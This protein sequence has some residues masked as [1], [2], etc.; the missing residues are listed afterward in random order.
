MSHSSEEQSP[1]SPLH[2]AESDHYSSAAIAKSFPWNRF[3]DALALQETTK[4][5]LVSEFSQNLNHAHRHPDRGFDLSP[6]PSKILE[7]H[8]IVDGKKGTPLEGGEYHFSLT[9]PSDYPFRRPR[10]ELHTENAKLHY[11]RPITDFIGGIETDYAVSWSLVDFIQGMR[12]LLH[13]PHDPSNDLSIDSTDEEVRD[14]ARHSQAHLVQN[15]AER[16]FLHRVFP[17]R[18]TNWYK[19]VWRDVTAKDHSLAAKLEHPDVVLER[20]GGERAWLDDATAHV[21]AAA[22]QAAATARSRRRASK[23]KK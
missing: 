6:H 3:D 18:Y 22:G 2:A 4:R 23:P 14:A 21:R 1:F 7:W 19:K 8:A 10:V 9:L 11:S 17:L 12:D 5:R 15:V 16:D 20:H 13:A